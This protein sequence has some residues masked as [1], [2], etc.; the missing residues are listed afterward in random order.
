MPIIAEG[1]KP[2]IVNHE[3][4]GQPFCAPQGLVR[5]LVRFFDRWS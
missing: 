2:A 5:R 3:A 4:H 1:P